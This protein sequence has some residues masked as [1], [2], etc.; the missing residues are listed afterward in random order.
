MTSSMS[1]FPPLPD[2]NGS[3]QVKLFEDAVGIRSSPAYPGQRTGAG[4][5]P[6]EVREFK[7]QR[8]VQHKGHDIYFY[9]LVDGRG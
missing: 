5:N 2:R 1:Q 7:A 3:L 6:G 4:V 8:V 9:E